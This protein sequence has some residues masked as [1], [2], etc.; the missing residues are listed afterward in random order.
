MHAGEEW[1]RKEGGRGRMVYRLLGTTE[2][3]CTLS[4]PEGMQPC[5]LPRNAA[6]DLAGGHDKA[7]DGPLYLPRL[8]LLGGGGGCW[9]SGGLV[10]GQ[11]RRRAV[12]DGRLTIRRVSPSGQSLPSVFLMRCNAG[13]ASRQ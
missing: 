4:R 5:F 1:T 3:T 11:R 13:T 6:L 8:P 9:L 2:T 12:L 7:T 10:R